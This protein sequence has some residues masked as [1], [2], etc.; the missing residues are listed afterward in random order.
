MELRQLSTFIRVAQLKSFSRAAESLGYSQSA[1]TVQIQQLEEE[2][3]TR[4]FDRMGKRISLTTPGTQF[5]EHAYEVINQVNRAKLSLSWEEELRGGLH[6]G[7]IESLCVSKLPAVVHHFWQRH[8]KV[9]L[10]VTT[11]ELEDLIEQMEQGEMD[12]IYILD[13]PQYNNRWCKLMEQREEI[14]L[15]AS[16][17]LLDQLPR[18]GELEMEQLLDKP[19]FLTEQNANYRRVLDRYLAARGRILTPFLEC[20]DTSF[21]IRMLEVDCG[22][23][24]LPR[25]VVEKNVDRGSL[26]VLNVRDLHVSLYQQ[27][28]CHKEKW[29]TRE[30]DE[31]VRAVEE[32]NFRPAMPKL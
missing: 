14:V 15:V 18:D 24:F 3:N 1:V 29:R 16:V 8:P 7:V 31:F 12:L 6:I 32:T 25:Y 28:F 5:L 13:E 9:V 26:A 19:F 10:R 30:M 17:M 27:I 23:S 4:L 20:S 11:G 2:L 21:I 22:L